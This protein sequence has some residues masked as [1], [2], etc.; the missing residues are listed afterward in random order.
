MNSTPQN[1][2][3][4]VF[5]LLEAV[6][7]AAPTFITVMAFRDGG[8]LSHHR[9]TILVFV[10]VGLTVLNLIVGKSRAALASRFGKR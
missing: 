9:I 7:L 4:Q 5:W 10:L 2:D 1:I 8:P 6:F 3:W